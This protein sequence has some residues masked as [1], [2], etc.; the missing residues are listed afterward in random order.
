M[1]RVNRSVNGGVYMS[2]LL[3]IYGQEMPHDDVRICGT[4]EGLQNLCKAIEKALADGQSITDV[5]FANDGEG[6]EVQVYVVDNKEFNS[7]EKPYSNEIY[8]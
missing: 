5:L 8:K 7:L 3:H 6:Y 4:R 2:N 1:L